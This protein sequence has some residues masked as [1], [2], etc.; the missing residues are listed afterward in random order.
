MPE[1]EHIWEIYFPK[2]WKISFKNSK[3]RIPRII[4]SNFLKWTQSRNVFQTTNSN[5]NDEA[6]SEVIKGIFP[7]Y[8]TDT[9]LSFLILL[10]SDSIKEAIQKRPNFSIIKIFCV[11]SSSEESWEEKSHLIDLKNHEL[12][13]ETIDVIFM[14]FHFWRPLKIY[15]TDITQEENE[16]WSKYSET[17]KKHITDKVRKRKLQTILNELNSIDIMNLCK[18]SEYYESQRKDFIKLITLL[19]Q[20]L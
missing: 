15:T 20:R 1:K 5:H 17:Q 4:L 12:E 10:F 6:L 16:N 19:F 3:K 2:E 18:V 7:N 14:Y 13:Q 11:S 9:F 8:H